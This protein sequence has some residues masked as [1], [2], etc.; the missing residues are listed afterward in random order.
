MFL[1]AFFVAAVESGFMSETAAVAAAG[2]TGIGPGGE[3]D[4]TSALVTEAVAEGG[5]GEAFLRASS[6]SDETEDAIGTEEDEEEAEEV[7]EEGG[8]AEERGGD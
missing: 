7:E 2:S 8:G 1:R 5:F 3:D 6:S 4:A